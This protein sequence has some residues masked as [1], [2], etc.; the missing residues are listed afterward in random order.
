[1][2]KQKLEVKMMLPYEEAV[3]YLESFLASLKSGRVVIR[4][5]DEVVSM[6]PA[7]QLHLTIGAKTKKG[8]HKFSFEAS[9]EDTTDSGFSISD[10]LPESVGDKSGEADEAA[11][12]HKAAAAPCPCGETAS[13]KPDE[14]APE[15]ATEADAGNAEADGVAGKP[16]ASKAAAKSASKPAAKKTAAKGKSAPASKAKTA[17][18]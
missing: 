5:D 9:W 2:E 11:S 18:K 1:M 12:K 6:E 10:K 4:K 16:K 7:E 13:A 3:E 17:K 15:P 8:R 14:A